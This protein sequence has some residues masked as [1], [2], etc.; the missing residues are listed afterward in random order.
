ML[1]SE[2]ASTVCE[3]QGRQR[4]LPEGAGP[5]PHPL[6]PGLRGTGSGI[7]PLEVLRRFF[8]ALNHLSSLSFL[9]YR[10]KPVPRS[11]FP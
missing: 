7:L 10:G 6:N 11:G 3:Q 2:V 1:F 4:G 9:P 8:C 5:T